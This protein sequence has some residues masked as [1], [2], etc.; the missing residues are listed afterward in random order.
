MTERRD[1]S[2]TALTDTLSVGAPGE[3]KKKYRPTGVYITKRQREIIAKIA[4]QTGQKDYAILR[5][6]ISFFLKEYERNP[7]IIQVETKQV[8]KQP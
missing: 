4:E 8:F 1:P 7:G 5:Y 2:R 3:A 6:A